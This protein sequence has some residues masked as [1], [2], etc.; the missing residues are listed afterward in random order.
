MNGKRIIRAAMLSGLCTIVIAA[1]AAVV[2]VGVPSIIKG[3]LI[4]Y[5]IWA[6]AILP[7]LVLGL[8]LD[9]PRSL[10]GL[11]SM[12]VGSTVA[13][14]FQLPALNATGFPAILPALA[15]ALLAY[16]IGHVL[17]REKGA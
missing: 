9:K 13:L 6:P 7:A 2:A 17:S 16:F 10:A 8:W 14:L 5:T 11:S 3:L 1:A 12:I 4:C 15:A